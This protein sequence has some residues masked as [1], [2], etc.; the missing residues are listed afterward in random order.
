MKG[1]NKIPI[2]YRLVKY[3]V[4]FVQ[5]K[6]YYK[7][8]YNLH[9]ENIPP[10]G[11]SLV[12]V[13]NHQNSLNDA[14]AIV[15]SIDLRRPRF[16]ARAD[17]FKKPIAAKFLNYFGLLPVYR[18][19][20][21]MDNVKKN[22]HIFDAVEDII[23]QGNTLVLY[24]EAGHQVRH[25]LGRFFLSYTRIAFGAA[26]RS[27]FEKEI[28]ILPCAN[29][30]S[31]YFK[32]REELIIAYGTPVSIKPYYELYKEQ[33][34]Q[35]QM[36]VNEIIKTQIESL[37]LNVKDEE[38]YEAIYFLLQTYGIKYTRHNGRNPDKLPEKL[39]MDQQLVAI[40]DTK[41]AE[42]PM[43]IK[44]L[45]QRVLVYKNKLNE[46]K[47]NNKTLDKPVGIATLITRMIFFILGFPFFLMGYLH[48]V[49]QYNIPRLIN[50]KVEDTMMHASINIGLS[51]L[52]FPFLYLLF[53]VLALVFTHSFIISFIYV[54]SLPLFG[55][56]AWNYRKAFFEFLKKWRFYTLLKLK[57]EELI[58]V[59]KLRDDIYKQMNLLTKT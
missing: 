17:I 12:V 41:Y 3:W 6:L 31:D 52:T 5:N 2:T 16:L 34:R 43:Q 50:R 44:D 37:M 1:S 19:F 46:L 57:N 7:K 45:Y 38:N 35:A 15:L 21:G 23:N 29:H 55:L 39:S 11:T 25:F 22:L 54:I 32:W 33:P 40:L 51:I 47:I 59:L 26:E 4:T 18:Q 13:S 53:F 36:Q 20:D 30:Y 58:E 14:L 8:V 10:K 49:I 24:P 42:N 27:N 9:T 56:I 28:F 48:H